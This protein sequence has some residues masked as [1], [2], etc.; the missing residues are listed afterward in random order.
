MAQTKIRIEQTEADVVGPTGATDGNL[1]VFDGATGKLIKDGGAVP[2][3]GGVTVAF[4]Q[5]N[6]N[7]AA[8]NDYAV[9]N[10]SWTALDSTNLVLVIA[11]VEGD[12]LAIGVSGKW[13]GNQY[14]ALTVATIVSAAVVNY[15]D[16]G[17]TTPG[18]NGV[19]GWMDYNNAAAPGSGQSFTGEFMWTV[20][21]GDI[22]GGDVTLHLYAKAFAAGKTILCR[23]GFP[24]QFYV[25]NLG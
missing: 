9:T 14:A 3:G 21:A 2:S 11:A 15:I 7:A 10:G 18:D 23:T 1:A 16:N 25:K 22:S 4:V 17:D 20:E 24:L 5:R 6:T 19:L 8:G 12:I 13:A